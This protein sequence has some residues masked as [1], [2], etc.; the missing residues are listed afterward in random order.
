MSFVRHG[1][2][3]T[4]ELGLRL[5]RKEETGGNPLSENR[6]NSKL[7]LH[8]TPGWNRNRATLLGGAKKYYYKKIYYKNYSL[9]Q[10][11]VVG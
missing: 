3:T 11:S 7:S 10:F 4:S 8:M 1:K 9:N 2:S 6:S 5:D